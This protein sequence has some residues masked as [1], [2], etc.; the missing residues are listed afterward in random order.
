MIAQQLAFKTTTPWV[1]WSRVGEVI[2][3]GLAP[4]LWAAK[5]G[6]DT[7]RPVALGVALSALAYLVIYFG[8]A[9]G[10]FST[11]RY[12]A[13]VAGLGF[14]TYP[15]VWAAPLIWTTRRYLTIN[16]RFGGNVIDLMLDDGSTKL[17]PS[18]NH[19]EHDNGDERGA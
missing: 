4:S 3:F 11:E 5:V 15:I 12:G 16:R 1:L 9:V 6:K 2:V 17:P 13:L 19:M 10:W 8:T 7:M 14:T 18:G